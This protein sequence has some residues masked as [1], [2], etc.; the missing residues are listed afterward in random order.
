[1]YKKIADIIIILIIIANFA[2]AILYYCDQSFF[3]KLDG[4]TIMTI[5][6]SMVGSWAIMGGLAFSVEMSK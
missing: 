3:E 4:D 1:M 5:A 6:L 2:I